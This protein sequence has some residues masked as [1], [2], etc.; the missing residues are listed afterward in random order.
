[1]GRESKQRSREGIPGAAVGLWWPETPEKVTCEPSP[2]G[3]MT[4]L[5]LSPFTRTSPNPLALTEQS[6]DHSIR[7][8]SFSQPPCA[9]AKESVIMKSIF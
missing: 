1:M 7:E 6:H 8:V 2:K 9:K 3:V 4:K 5:S